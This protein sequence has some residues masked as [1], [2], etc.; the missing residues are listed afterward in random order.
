[1]DVKWIIESHELTK[2]PNKKA[3]LKFFNPSELENI[4]FT[5]DRTIQETVRKIAPV[6]LQYGG[7][8]LGVLI[9]IVACIVVTV[10]EEILGGL[11]MFAL[12]VIVLGAAF[13]YRDQLHQR[14]WKKIAQELQ[15]YFKKLSRRHPGVQ[16]EFHIQGHHT[17]SDD[18]DESYSRSSQSSKSGRSKKERKQKKSKKSKKS[19]RKQKEK[20]KK[21][22]I[23]TTVWYERYIMIALPHEDYVPQPIVKEDRNN[24]HRIYD[25]EEQS[26]QGYVQNAPPAPAA[27]GGT[28]VLPYW[29]VRSKDEDG[30]TY[31]INNFKKSTQWTAPSKEQIEKERAEMSSVLP[32]PQ[33]NPQHRSAGRFNEV[34]RKSLSKRRSIIETRHR[35]SLKLTVKPEETDTEPQPEP[36]GEPE[37]L[38]RRTR[39]KSS[40]RQKKKSKKKRRRKE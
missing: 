15:Q 36:V 9:M 24:D 16:F 31:Y 17:K 1:M 39:S 35:N 20:Q 8:I 33:Y 29:W 37:R 10:P 25:V 27:A 5:V 4:Q 3:M 34:K 30:R 7:F 32:P 38:D 28:V 2:C 13:W 22:S 12:G 21:E 40:N 18:R 26:D 6:W 14:K 19:K 23:R 11:L